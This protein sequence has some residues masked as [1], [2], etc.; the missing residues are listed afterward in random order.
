MPTP[1]DLVCGLTVA[2][3][4]VPAVVRAAD[5]ERARAMAPVI[6]ELPPDR[7]VP[8]VE[9]EYTATSGPVPSVPPDEI[10]GPVCLWREGAVLRL[11]YADGRVTATAT[12]NAIRAG[13]DGVDLADAW[14]FVFH[15][16][17]AHVLALH[18]R[19]L[20]HAGAIANDGGALIVTGASGSGKSTLVLAALDAGWSAL[21]DDLV[22]VRPG[23][24]GP[25]VCGIAKPFRVPSELLVTAAGTTDGRPASRDRS[26]VSGHEWL[27]GWVRVRAPVAVGHNDAPHAEVT[28]VRATAAVELAVSAFI[29]MGDASQLR[30]YLPIASGI[31]KHGGYRLQHGNDSSTRLLEAA[32]ALAS[33]GAP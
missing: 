13:G 19:Y 22:A 12:A 3:G 7:R 29:G 15:Y 9:V 27:P 32:G 16:A 20:L 14:R 33:L 4:D 23:A 17:L 28:P 1:R 11:S 31:G 30:S 5:V 26:H 25:E 2:L 8:V 18:G 24:T 10:H 21:S 6:G